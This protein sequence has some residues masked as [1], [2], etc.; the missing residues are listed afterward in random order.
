MKIISRGLI[1]VA[2]VL[3]SDAARAAD[4]PAVTTFEAD[5]LV[6][7]VF[8]LFPR[9]LKDK[10]QADQAHARATLREVA[11]RALA[12]GRRDIDVAAVT[13]PDPRARPYATA[14]TQALHDEF[15]LLVQRL[16]AGA[17]VASPSPIHTSVF[18]RRTLTEV[19]HA[20]KTQRETGGVDRIHSALHGIGLQENR[21]QG[22][23]RRQYL[24]LTNHCHEENR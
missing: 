7:D 12:T 19:E 22:S 24:R 1:V 9:A 20:I 5:G 8:D 13:G 16:E 11:A 10:K 15:L 4:G 21:P 14:R 2:L 23:R 6:V 17:G 18:V 3:S